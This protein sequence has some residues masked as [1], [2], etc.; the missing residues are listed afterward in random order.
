MG[1]YTTVAMLC[2]FC[3][4][5]IA[6]EVTKEICTATL[7]ELGLPIA[8]YEFKDG[9]IF[10][11]HVF[12][13]SV[14][15]FEAGGYIVVRSDGEV[16]AED[17]YFGKKSLAARDAALAIQAKENDRLVK[18]LADDLDALQAETDRLLDKIRNNE[19]PKSISS[20]LAINLEK[21]EAKAKAKAEKEGTR[22]AERAAKK[23]KERADEALEQAIK[24]KQGFHCL[25]GW[26]GSHR[27]VVK[28]VKKSLNDPSSFDHDATHV[29]PLSEGQHQFEMTYR[30]KNSFGALVLNKV[31]GS[32]SG[33]D[34]AVIA[35]SQSN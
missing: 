10:D 11:S 8:P 18:A 28:A 12:D 14:S 15:C 21:E 32:Y 6:L 13:G 35:I 16:Y 30:A 7:T 26:D 27:E 25:S 2:I 24:K 23:E 22:R 3:N 4:S 34:C 31:V 19:I 1:K 5:A 20:A 9:W 29:T 17:G 33:S